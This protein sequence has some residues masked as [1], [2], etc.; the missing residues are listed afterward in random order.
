[1]ANRW[2]TQFFGT[3]HKK[4]VMMDCDFIVDSTNGNG[5]GVRSLKGAGIARVYMHTTASFTGNT[6][7]TVVVDG[8]AGGTAS[9]QPGMP[10]SGSGIVAGT[11][12]ASI[13]SSS[14]VNLTI[15]AGTTVSGDVISYAAVGSPTPSGPSSSY[16][17][18]TFQDNFNYYMFGTAGF[19][20]PISGT[21]ISIS[22]SSVMTIG[23]PYVI[24]SVGS[25]TQANWN[26]VGLPLGIIPAVGEA[27][28][29]TVTGGGTGSGVVEAPSVSGCT[30]IEVV[31]DPNQT[32]GANYNGASIL[33][34]SA[35]SYMILQC[36][37]G[38]TPTAPANGSVIGLSFFMSNSYIAVQ[39]Y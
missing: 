4:P 36:L 9:L 34:G 10:V 16:I 14:S 23:N 30:S 18:V 33:G 12:I 1:M 24:V 29:A 27:F 21:P 22:G 26:A 8:I 32:F 28:I 13:V 11:Q 35:G 7:G 2:Y 17:L 38:S 5:F 6:H 39:G 15:P 3:L 20:S 25:S 37:N 19:V 31:G